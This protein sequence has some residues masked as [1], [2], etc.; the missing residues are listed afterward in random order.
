MHMARLPELM[1]LLDQ[2]PF[3]PEK[4]SATRRAVETG[5]ILLGFG[6]LALLLI[7]AP[8]PAMLAAGMPDF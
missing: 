1:L 7:D 4:R 3:V 8:A 6:V 5:L 2:T